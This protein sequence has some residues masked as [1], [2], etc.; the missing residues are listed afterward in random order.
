M[1]FVRP[2]PAPIPGTDPATGE[3]TRFAT[4]NAAL[5]AAARARS[6]LQKDFLT[7]SVTP[8]GR[9]NVHRQLLAPVE[10]QLR[11]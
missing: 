2:R 3:S 11:A 5:A 6:H 4:A 10:G 1:R 8:V 7:V 9:G